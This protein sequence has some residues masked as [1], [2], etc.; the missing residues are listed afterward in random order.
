MPKFLLGEQACY[1]LNNLNLKPTHHENTGFR[2]KR[3]YLEQN[4]T[5]RLYLEQN[6]SN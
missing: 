1:I 5:K 3:L 4:N 6:N 2:T